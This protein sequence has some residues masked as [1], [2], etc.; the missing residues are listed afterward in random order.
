MLI[1]TENLYMIKNLAN[2]LWYYY[3]IATMIPLFIMTTWKLYKPV[4][5][6]KVP[7]NW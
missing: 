3:S 6:D 1:S 5:Y 2:Y 4:D 7:K